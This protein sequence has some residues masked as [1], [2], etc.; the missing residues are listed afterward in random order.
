LAFTVV[1]E[2]PLISI[3][4]VAAAA[5]IVALKGV[6][7]LFSGVFFREKKLVGGAPPESRLERIIPRGAK[8]IAIVGQNLAARFDEGYDSLLQSLRMLLSRRDSV[9]ELW[10]VLQTPLALSVVHPA[11]ARHL[12]N[13]TM[14]GLQRLSNDLGELASRARVAFHPAATLSMIVVDWHTDRR[15]CVVEPK[16]QTLPI[17]GRR[18]SVVLS[19]EAFDQV[20]PHFDQF[21]SEARR[22][23]FP[24]A[25]SVDLQEAAAT[26]RLMFDQLVVTQVQQF[27]ESEEIRV[28]SA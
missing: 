16:V 3:R 5:V 7:G 28:R 24:G 26:L 8:R 18:L 2:G 19:G 13:V 6:L 20:A 4:A 9:E 21:L 27:V 23:E 14:N 10:I 15:L 17:I 11:A 1:F 12:R 22:K 25:A